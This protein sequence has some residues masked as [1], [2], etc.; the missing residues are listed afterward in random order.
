MTK[1]TGCGFSGVENFLQE[2]FLL[3]LL[4]E[5]PRFIPPIVGTLIKILLKKSS[6]GLQDLLTSDD[7]KYLSLICASSEL[8]ASIPGERKFST[9]GRLLVL[10]EETRDRQKIWYDAND[11]KLKGLV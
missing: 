10:R 6:L 5:K 2:I 9:S 3:C 7:K 11:A 1:D 8:I 4:F